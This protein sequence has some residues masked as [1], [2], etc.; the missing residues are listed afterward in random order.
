MAGG[1]APCGRY[2]GL[3]GLSLLHRSHLRRSNLRGSNLGR[4]DLGRSNLGRSNLGGGHLGVVMMMQVR[5]GHQAGL[6][7][8]AGCG[9]LQLLLSLGLA[10]GGRGHLL[11]AVFVAAAVDLVDVLL[12]LRGRCRLL[13]I[14][15]LGLRLALATSGRGHLLSAVFVAAAIG[16]V[17]LLGRGILLLLG[18]R[19]RLLRVLGAGRGLLQ[20]LLRL[21]LATGGRCYLLSAVFVAAAVGLVN[22]RQVMRAGESNR[23]GLTH[24][25]MDLACAVLVATGKS[26]IG[27]QRDS[28]GIGNLHR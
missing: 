5:P 2:L 28:A 10:A 14:L 3:L 1:D 6:L 13:R 16:L 22:D 27:H 24:R 7:L 20:L 21:R 12:L 26:D 19:C 15:L 9:L 11:G 17:D 18:G 8:R 23:H 4:S 25:L